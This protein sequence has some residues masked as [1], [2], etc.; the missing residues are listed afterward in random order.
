[1][2]VDSLS[3]DHEKTDQKASALT[4]QVATLETQLTDAHEALQEETKQ[5]LQF[6]VQLKQSEDRVSGLQ[7]QLD[8]VE[9][10]KKALET[11]LGSQATQVC[12]ID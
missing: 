1:M 12:M 6:Q 3:K 9:E 2:E 7:E 5:K 11:K 10:E 4:K 8:D